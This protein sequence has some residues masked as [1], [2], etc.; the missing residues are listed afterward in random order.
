[1]H[2]YWASFFNRIKLVNLSCS[3]LRNLVSKLDS[4]V[5]HIWD[6]A[7]LIRWR[8]SI[9]ESVL[10][11]AFGHFWPGHPL[12]PAAVAFFCCI[13]KLLYWR[14]LNVRPA[15]VKSYFLTS[16]CFLKHL[17]FI[18]ILFCGFV[19]IPLDSAAKLMAPKF[20]KLCSQSAWEWQEV[21]RKTVRII[22]LGISYK[23]IYKVEKLSRA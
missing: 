5:N 12:H 15:N 16:F 2:I 9:D 11:A 20:K 8:N 10:L 17:F 6:V 3:C 21:G 18:Y 14:L 7:F 22:G 19:R 4:D 23:V 13:W 1:M